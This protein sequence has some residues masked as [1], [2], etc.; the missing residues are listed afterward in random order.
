MNSEGMSIREILDETRQSVNRL[1]EE[2][3]EFKHQVV[4]KSDFNAFHEAEKTARRYFITTMITV[5]TLFLTGIG[6]VVGAIL[7]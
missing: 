2:F 5:V 7:S 1:V 6:I 3:Q 4:Y